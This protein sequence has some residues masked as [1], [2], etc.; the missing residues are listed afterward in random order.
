MQGI[1]G[2]V[3][4]NSFVTF[5]HYKQRPIYIS[6]GRTQDALKRTSQ[7]M[8][9]EKESRKSVLS[10][11]LNGEAHD[12]RKRDWQFGVIFQ[13]NTLCLELTKILEVNS[14][15]SHYNYLLH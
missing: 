1:A 6:S 7:E 9:N 10:A 2:E 15:L 13:S 8:R 11:R 3:S 12:D 4:T 5:P 14:N